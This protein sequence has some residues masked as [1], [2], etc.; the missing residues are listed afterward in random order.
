M[1]AMQKLAPEMKR[2]QEKHRNDRQALSAAQME[3]YKT[4][5]VSPFGSCLYSR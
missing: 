2:L 1:L 5:N 3:L 4:N